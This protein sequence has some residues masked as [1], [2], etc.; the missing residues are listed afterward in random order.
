MG[1][2]PNHIGYSRL[3]SLVLVCGL[4]LII[5]FLFVLLIGMLEHRWL[6]IGKVPKFKWDRGDGSPCLINRR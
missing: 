3:S 4:G 2:F 6:L 1:H 5:T